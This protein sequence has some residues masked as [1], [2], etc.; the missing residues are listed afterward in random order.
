MKAALLGGERGRLAVLAAAKCAATGACRA[1]PLVGGVF[2][3]SLIVGALGGAAVGSSCAYYS[4]A[5]CLGALFRA[6]ATGA[7]LVTELFGAPG[8]FL[9]SL[10]AAAGA[11]WVAGRE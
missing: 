9:P 3:P 11:C 2:A 10:A 4:A 6:P 5:A 7:L 1:S 8:L